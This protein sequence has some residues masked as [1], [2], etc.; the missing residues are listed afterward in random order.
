MRAAKPPFTY[1]H[2][3]DDHYHHNTGCVQNIYM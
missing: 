1:K 2:N 3:D